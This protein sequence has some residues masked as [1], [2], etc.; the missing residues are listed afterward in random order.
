MSKHFDLDQLALRASDVVLDNGSMDGLD[1]LEG[2]FPCQD[3]RIGPL[4]EEFYGLGVRDVALGRDVD[5]LSDA[6]GIEDGGHIGGD[7]GIDPLTA[8]TVD[9]LLHGAQF[10]LI[11]DGIDRQVGLYPRSVG[12]SHNLGQVVEGKVGRRG[13]THIEFAH[14]EID[15]VGTRLDGGSQCFVRP[16]GGHQ[17]DV[18]S[19]HYRTS[20]LIVATHQ[21]QGVGTQG[22][23]SLGG[24]IQCIE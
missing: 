17:F 23:H 24:G 16:H 1:L 4:R 6:A 5:L 2:Q 9:D 19:F 8:G 13:R 11:D 21:T 20:G 22:G 7:D 15:R 14:P 3:H 12:R 10:V 18:A